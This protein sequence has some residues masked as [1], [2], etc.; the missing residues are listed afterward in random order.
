MA[1]TF[2]VVILAAGE[3]TRLKLDVAKPLAPIMGEKLIDFP[4]RAAINFFER[5]N[6]EGE[7]VVVIGHQKES[8]QEHISNTF[9]GSPIGYAIQEIPR[10]TADAVKSYFESNPETKNKKYTMVLCAD[11]PVIDEEDLEKLFKVLETEKARGV[12]ATFEAQVPTGYGR[13]IREDRGFKIV[14]EKEATEEQRKIKEVNSGL[15]IVETEYLLSHLY[16]LDSNNQAGEFYLTDIFK[17]DEN[18]KAVLYENASTF[19]GVNTVE[20]LMA[21]ETFLKAKQGNSGES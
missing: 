16:D 8:V 18:V 14:E 7:I 3:G 13:I 5:K 17:T 19:Q 20:Q 10:G 15:Y 6:F 11:T 2:G 9:S 12:A 21:A 4:L 1:D